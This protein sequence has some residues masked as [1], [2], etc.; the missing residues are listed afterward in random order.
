MN[1]RSLPLTTHWVF[2]FSFRIRLKMQNRMFGTSRPGIPMT[3]DKQLRGIKL[4]SV[5][6]KQRLGQALNIKEFAVLAGVSYS[7]ARD[8][9]QLK[10]FPRFE[11]VVFWEDF[12]AWRNDRNGAKAADKH[13]PQPASSF[14][15]ESKRPV[16]AGLPPRAA[17]ILLESVK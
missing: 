16:S 11:G 6:E 14:L 10:G 5:L 13:P 12:V 7:V 1:G 3:K 2:A 8:W 15:P 17:Q 4:A 9:F